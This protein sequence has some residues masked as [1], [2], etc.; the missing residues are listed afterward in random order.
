MKLKFNI[1]QKISNTYTYFALQYFFAQEI[2][3]NLL[4]SCHLV[5][6][7]KLL[8]LIL[9]HIMT[10]GGVKAIVR[11]WKWYR[12]VQNI[13]NNQ[14]LLMDRVVVTHRIYHL[15]GSKYTVERTKNCQGPLIEIRWHTLQ[16]KKSYCD[17]LASG[18]VL[19]LTT[20]TPVV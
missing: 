19:L 3:S 11:Q 4:A 18:V 15:Q 8:E 9:L 7:V 2:C 14:T 6:Y 10:C 1:Q 20:N 12:C 13:S 5:F 17:M 16:E